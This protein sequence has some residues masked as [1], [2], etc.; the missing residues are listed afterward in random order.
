MIFL[1]DFG[2]IFM[3]KKLTPSFQFSCATLY[4]SSLP[5][6]SFIMVQATAPE[7]CYHI[8]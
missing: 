2:F 6:S 8:A 1:Q 3:Y 4:S 5:F 7:N